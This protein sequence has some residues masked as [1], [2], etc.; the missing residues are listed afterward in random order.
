MDSAKDGK[1]W[2]NDAQ[3]VAYLRAFRDY[4]ID[5]EVLPAEQAAGLIRARLVHLELAGALDHWVGGLGPSPRR[6]KLIAIAR[7][8][9][10]D[11]WRNRVRDALWAG[12]RGQAVLAEL[13]A[14]E[15]VR[16]LPPATVNSLAFAVRSAGLLND[17]VALLRDAQQRHP[18]DFWIN[19]NLAWS[20]DQKRPP[21]RDEAVRFYSVALALRPGSI[22]TLNNLAND[23]RENGRADE[24]IPYLRKAIEIDPNYVRAHNSLG[25][26]LRAQGKLAE[27][28][29]AC[30]KAIEIDPNFAPAHNNLGL[31]LADQKKPEEA[32]VCYR[33]AI[34]L[35][36]KDANPTSTSATL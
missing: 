28:I 15:K 26:V 8:V 25:S 32:I 9:D 7:A 35:D 21:S 10:S 5:V 27:A 31:A 2:N 18:D 13:V 33:K 14:S 6:N 36:P 16:A 11:E 24:A 29:D 17:A 4:G 22:A 23:L 30:R 20:L 3:A 12:Q 19:F 34:E 1:A